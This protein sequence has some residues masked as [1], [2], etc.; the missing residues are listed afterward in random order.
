MLATMATRDDLYR[1]LVERLAGRIQG[2]DLQE[3]AGDVKSIDRRAS[4]LAAAVFGW[5]DDHGIN[6][7]DD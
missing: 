3:V 5:A 4:E 1:D 6:L 7:G 2:S